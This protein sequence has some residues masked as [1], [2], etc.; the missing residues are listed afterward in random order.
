MW[1]T[2][3]LHHHEMP[4]TDIHSRRQIL[5]Q[6]Y[7][8]KLPNMPLSSR[9][10]MLPHLSDSW[11]C[12]TLY[13]VKMRPTQFSRLTFIS[14]VRNSIE[15]AVNYYLVLKPALSWPQVLEV[16]PV[17]KKAMLISAFSNGLNGRR[18]FVWRSSDSYNSYTLYPIPYS[19]DPVDRCVTVASSTSST[20]SSWHSR[21]M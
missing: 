1:I 21:T 16:Q 12:G 19:P 13:A 6:I 8:Q 3:I 17:G 18:L 7:R 14:V 11:Q 4:S 9:T 2:Y 15:L 10:Q 5:T 20:I